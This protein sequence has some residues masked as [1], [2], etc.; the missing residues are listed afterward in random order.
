MRW[1]RV[2]GAVLLLISLV[3]ILPTSGLDYSGWEK[4]RY[5]E[6]KNPYDELIDHQVLINM[7]TKKLI[8]DGLMRPDCGDLRF[9]DLDGNP[10]PYWIGSGCGTFDTKVWVRVPKLTPGDNRIMVYYGNPLA[11][12]ESD[13]VATMD[14]AVAY[15]GSNYDEFYAT[16]SDGKNVYMAGYTLSTGFGG[17]DGLIV[18]FDEELNVVKAKVYGGFSYDGFYGAHSD[19]KYVYAV[20]YTYSEGAGGYDA[21]IVK[22][23]RDLNVVAKKVI[24]GRSHDWF[25]EVTGDDRYLYA[26]GYTRSSGLGD[27]DAYIV[28]MDK[29]LN[30]LAVRALGSTTYD[31]FHYVALSGDYVYAVGVTTSGFGNED[32][33]I[34]KFDKDLNLIA[35]KVYGGTSYDFF[36]GVAASG[37]YLYVAGYV[38]SAGS[39]GHDGL[40]VKFDEDLNLI[41][42]RAYGGA[43][44]DG[45]ATL[46]P[47]KGQI[48]VVGFTDSEGRGGRDSLV[49]KLNAD[50]SLV[51]ARRYGGSGNEWM[52]EIMGLN[53]YIYLGGFTDTIGSGA[54]DAM[55]TRIYKLFNQVSIDPAFTFANSSLTYQRISL[56]LADST[57][58]FVAPTF[59]SSDS[60]LNERDS[61][62]ALSRTFLRK[63]PDL[64]GHLGPEVSEEAERRKIRTPDPGRMQCT[65]SLS[66]FPVSHYYV[67]TLSDFKFNEDIL[68][69]LRGY[70]INVNWSSGIY[71][72]PFLYVGGPDKIPFPWESYGVAFIKEGR[73]YTALEYRGSIYRATHGY[74]DYAVVLVDCSTRDVRIAGIT[75]YG[76]RAGL[77]WAVNYVK[78]LGYDGLF[79]VRWVDGNRNGLVE[80]FEL[81]VVRQ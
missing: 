7:N 14:R 11:E 39:G 18:K 52:S 65:L 78:S 46:R 81:T 38:D 70:I 23:D 19:G 67:T 45:F 48:Y 68:S 16:T 22:F 43:A 2:G 64:T 9:S 79:L 24:G 17:Y 41:D 34:A 59:T 47:Y 75:E 80:S 44:D 4:A 31:G 10:L 40:I 6:I 21:I 50:L 54:R 69:M 61:G 49:L 20:G 33:L 5:V 71:H 57:L 36:Y 26:V 30:V 12:S 73:K 76:T 28:K 35:A 66:Q 42:Q 53:D 37:G 15:G 56:S 8:D 74:E 55:V 32:G 72:G 58:T 29:D 1:G 77:I 51:A 63:I 60:S 25:Y 3:I 27:Y 13:E 62:L